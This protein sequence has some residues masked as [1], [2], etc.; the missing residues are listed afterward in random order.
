M[1][2]ANAVI[3]TRLRDRDAAPILQANLLRYRSGARRLAEAAKPVGVLIPLLSSILPTG[4]DET[5]PDRMREVV[6][7]RF[8]WAEPSEGE[9]PTTDRAIRVGRQLVAYLGGTKSI[10]L[11]PTVD[12]G[13]RFQAK[14]H[15]HL[16]S[17]VVNPHAGMVALVTVAPSY[18]TQQWDVHSVVA[19]AAFLMSA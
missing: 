15:S 12:G 3:G 1:S 17:V 18:E 4:S 6:S 16:R 7:N 10:A 9:V 8:I 19:A 13:L 5:L 14:Q 11:F 2:A